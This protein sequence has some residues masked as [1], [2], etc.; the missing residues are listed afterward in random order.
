[1]AAA[2][3]GAEPEVQV[4][5]GCMLDHVPTFAIP[6]WFIGC[7]GGVESRDEPIQEVPHNCIAILRFCFDPSYHS[8]DAVVCLSKAHRHHSAQDAGHILVA[9][10]AKAQDA[11]AFLSTAELDSVEWDEANAEHLA[12]TGEAFVPIDDGGRIKFV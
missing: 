2:P 5:S 9:F 10:K 7:V 12:S 6:G 1:M 4:N 11:E 8:L 3:F